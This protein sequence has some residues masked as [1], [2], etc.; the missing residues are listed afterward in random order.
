MKPKRFFVYWN[1]NFDAAR[2][3]RI[4]AGE[5]SDH[6]RQIGKTVQVSSI[7]VSDPGADVSHFHSGTTTIQCVSVN[8]NDEEVARQ[9]NPSLVDVDTMIENV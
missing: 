3:A 9:T 2:H 1:S 5:G 6:A 8:E 7:D 4:L